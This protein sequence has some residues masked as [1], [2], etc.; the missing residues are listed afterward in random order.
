MPFSFLNPSVSIKSLLIL[1]FA[2]ISFFACNSKKNDQ[3]EEQIKISQDDDQPD[4]PDSLLNSLQRNLAFNQVATT[5]H[6]VILTGLADHRL[7]TVY[8]SAPAQ[9]GAGNEKFS[10]R[11]VI[12][13]SDG[14]EEVT[15][16]MPGIDILYGYNLLNVA[17]Y[18][19]KGGRQNLFFKSPV[20][21]KTLYYPS[22]VQDSLDKKPI[23]RNYYL[24]SVYDEDTNKDTLINKRDLRRLYYFDESSTV[25]IRL[26]PEDYSVIR[27]QYDPGNDVM[28][29][30]ARHDADKNG[31]GNKG[32]PVHI[33]W[34]N[35][36][37]PV[38]A[39][40]LY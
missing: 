27:S 4:Q 36:K 18:D 37:Q 8:K 17:H 32:E 39:T 5:P 40:R 11:S 25:R 15:H 16:F 29:V 24:V 34:I 19:L 3:K 30:F 31:T 7:V 1:S 9:E 21:I 14:S 38:R 35:L 22:F 12:Y 2:L 6:T 10:S 20:L 13:S 26:V 28:Y 23:T 33:F